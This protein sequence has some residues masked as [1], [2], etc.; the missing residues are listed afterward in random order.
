MFSLGILCLS[1]SLEITSLLTKSK[2]RLLGRIKLLQY[3]LVP[4]S[5]KVKENFNFK[6]EEAMVNRMTS[7]IGGSIEAAIAAN[8]L[9]SLFLYLSDH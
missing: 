9:L 5:I 1:N 6:G 3:K 7:I 2:P 4:N 8:L